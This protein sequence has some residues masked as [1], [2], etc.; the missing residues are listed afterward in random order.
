[1]SD[2]P[3]TG[4]AQETADLPPPPPPE[5]SYFEKLLAYIP[6][7]IV[8]AVL[9]MDGM[10]KE[11][12]PDRPLWLYWAMFFAATLLTPLYVVFRPTENP[13]INCTKRFRAVTA[14]IAFSVWMFA[15]GGP[16][17]VTFEWYRPIFGSLLLIITTPVFEK[18]AERFKF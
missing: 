9:V 11:A 7:E 5:A 17:A 16:F 4:P 3:N 8:G 12:A 10:L 18:V 6:A 15:I 14:T 13:A 2:N 1:M